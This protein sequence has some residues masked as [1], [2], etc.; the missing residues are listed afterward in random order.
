MLRTNQDLLC[1][2]LGTSKN[3]THTKEDKTCEPEEEESWV[4]GSSLGTTS[5]R[6]EGRGTVGHSLVG[7]VE[8]RLAL[9]EGSKRT[10]GFQVAVGLIFWPLISHSCFLMRPG[11][12]NV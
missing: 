2:H 12:L 7:E 6:A 5:S 1:H 11:P 4:H 9:A 8:D 10:E 3:L